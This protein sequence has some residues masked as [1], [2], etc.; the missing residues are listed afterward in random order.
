MHPI[1]DS[2]QNNISFPSRVGQVAKTDISMEDQS[3][4]QGSKQVK[5]RFSEASEKANRHET[6]FD[7]QTLAGGFLENNHTQSV[8][9]NKSTTGPHSQ[10]TPVPMQRMLDTIK[11]LMQSHNAQRVSFELDLAQGEKLKVRLQLSGDQ[12]KSMFTTDSNTMKHII[13][14][15]WD[16]LQR[17]VESE[18]FNL[19][20][21]DF[22]DRN[23]QQTNDA[24]EQSAENEFFQVDPKPSGTMDHS[25]ENNNEGAQ[26]RA[27]SHTDEH[28]EV[29]RYA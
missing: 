17:Q 27:G 11:E 3:L 16:Q 22:T 19:A 25:R 7:K 15:N 1:P 9:T 12:V 6:K 28:S 18:G 21:P 13:R 23:P 4:I 29:I 20:Q 8:S 26:P 5:E 2:R 10:S 14:E 24:D